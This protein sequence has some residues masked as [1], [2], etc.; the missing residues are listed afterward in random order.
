MLKTS[1]DQVPVL[2]EAMLRRLDRPGPRYTSYP[3]AD[4][5]VEAFGP[6]DYALALAHRVSGAVVGGKPPLSIYVHIP[7]CE[8]VCYYC[9]CNKVITKHHER[10]AEYLEVLA[11]EV[12]LNVSVLG[13]GQ[14]VTQL[15]LGGGTPTFLS[16][17]ELSSLMAM[18]GRAFRLAPGAEVSI[19]VD[20][21]TASPDRLRHFAKLGFNRL[22]FGVQD[23]DADVQKAVH[24]VQPFESVR[25]LMLAAREIGF[26]S[27]NADLI[28]A[29]DRLRICQRGSD[30]W[31][32]QTD[33][34]VVCP[35]SQ[36]GG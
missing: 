27:I 8:S 18:L 35:N 26:E 10:A 36:S 13:G 23:F 2:T 16:D 22:S 19:E 12:A 34:R 21:R 30:L 24:R 32:A 29:R 1:A 5:F 20:P 15:H 3:T 7:F 28:R 25:D 6:A 17:A 31:P 9:A 4:R 14:A 11:Q 33:P